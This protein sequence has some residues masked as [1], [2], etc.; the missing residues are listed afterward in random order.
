MSSRMQD[1]AEEKRLEGERAARPSL[2]QLLIPS[3]VLAERFGV[4]KLFPDQGPH[5][6]AAVEEIDDDE[7]PNWPAAVEMI[8]DVG[9]RVRQARRYA[10]DVVQHSQAVVETTMHRLEEAERRLRLA[11]IA[12]REAQ[13]RAERAEQ[14]AQMSE[15]RA[16]RAEEETELNRAKLAE[17]QIWLKR[18]YSSVQI[19][20]KDLSE[21]QD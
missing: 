11:E 14:A 20:F 12:A 13:M 5:G 10:Q 1:R 18:L 7:E 8:R 2:R 15:A 9:A 17:A 21:E 3:R 16:R 19:E 4:V 6:P